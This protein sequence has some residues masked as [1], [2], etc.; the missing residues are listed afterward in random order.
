[1]PSKLFLIIEICSFSLTIE[2]Q[3]CSKT[4]MTLAF[5]AS[6]GNFAITPLPLR[7]KLLAQ[8]TRLQELILQTFR[9]ETRLLI[10]RH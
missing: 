3:N 6:T 7:Q 8:M 5:G 10:A 4:L 2:N 1:M 9:Y